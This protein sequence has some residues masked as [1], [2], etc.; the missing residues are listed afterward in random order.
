MSFVRQALSQLRDYKRFSPRPVTRL[1]ALFPRRPDQH[2]IELL[3]DYGIDC[4]YLDS[5]GA[6]ITLPAPPEP[7]APHRSHL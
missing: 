6:F 5:D 2:G 4:I 3:H 1:A 7:A